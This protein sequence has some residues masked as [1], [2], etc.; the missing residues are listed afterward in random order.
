M[1]WDWSTRL[2]TL[3]LCSVIVHGH[4]AVT[5]DLTLECPPGR[6]V[7]PIRALC[8]LPAYGSHVP[9]S[10]ESPNNCVVRSI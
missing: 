9:G 7:Q 1:S 5:S 8:G 10:E 2:N 3:L 6:A 4:C